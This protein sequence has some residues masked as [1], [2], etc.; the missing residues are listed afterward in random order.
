VGVFGA[1]QWTPLCNAESRYEERSGWLN[2]L[3]AVDDLQNLKISRPELE[4]L[5]F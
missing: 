5:I 3:T 2:F 1:S 4:K